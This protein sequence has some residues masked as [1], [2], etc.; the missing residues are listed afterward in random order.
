MAR[1][2]RPKRKVL[3]LIAA[4]LASGCSFVPRTQVEECHRLSQTLRSENAQLKD[5]VLAIKSQNRDL[6]ERAVD[7]S[8]RLTQLEEANNRLVESVQTYQDERSRLETAF[9]ELRA[10]LPGSS[11]PLSFKAHDEEKVATKVAEEPG[12]ELKRPRRPSTNKRTESLGR[13]DKRMRGDDPWVA[14][15]PVSQPEPRPGV[16]DP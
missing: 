5:Q 8:R 14:S 9:K 13:N 16:S 3:P 12:R 6:S 4:L 10:T 2:P 15:R 11:Q 1:L 7:D